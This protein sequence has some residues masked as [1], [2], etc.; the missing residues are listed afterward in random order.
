MMLE[1]LDIYIQNNKAPWNPLHLTPYTDLICTSLVAQT[2]QNPPEMQE[3]WVQSLGQ[4]DALEKG[5]ATHPSILTQIIPW[6]EEPGGV[7]SMESQ[8]SR[9]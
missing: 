9:T 4:E 7:Q 6:T 2:V 3:T 8:K 1:H 5:M